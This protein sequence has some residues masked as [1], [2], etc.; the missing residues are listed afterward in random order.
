LLSIHFL[1]SAPI[2]RNS[3]FRTGGSSREPLAAVRE[4]EEDLGS[5]PDE[6]ALC[7]M[8]GRLL[9]LLLETS[10]LER[11]IC[12]SVGSIEELGRLPEAMPLFE[13]LPLREDDA[14]VF[15]ESIT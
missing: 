2:E 6:W 13:V 4:R 11:A 1:L 10:R 15:S 3:K 9:L 14:R 8:A 5:R 7:I 12:C